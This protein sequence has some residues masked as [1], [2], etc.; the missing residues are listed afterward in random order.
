MRRV[1]TA[2]KDAQ[3]QTGPGEVGRT[4]Q[5]WAEGVGGEAKTSGVGKK[6]EG[7][8][9]KGFGSSLA[10]KNKKRTLPGVLNRVTSRLGL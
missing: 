9:R 6:K 3:T 1:Q 8:R 4:R 5:G 10:R 2:S 7:K